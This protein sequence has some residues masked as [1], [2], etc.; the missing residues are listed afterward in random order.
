[1]VAFGGGTRLA[2][3]T[4][5]QSG[6]G[7]GARWALAGG[8]GAFALSLAVLHLGAEWTSMRDRTF[9]GRIVLAPLALTLAAAGGHIPPVWF[10]AVVA[11]AVLGQLILEAF[12]FRAGAATI[13]A[14][15]NVGRRHRDGAGE[16][17]VNRGRRKYGERVST[18]A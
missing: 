3:T 18:S 9:T 2:I 1:V 8:I 4:A 5:T 13:T 10:V 7:A 15:V 12:T 14:P 6:P 16:D 17:S 11:A